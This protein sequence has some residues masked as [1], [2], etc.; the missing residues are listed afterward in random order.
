MFGLT[1]NETRILQ[2]LSTPIRIQNFL[3]TLDMNFEMQGDTCM[4]PRR[5]LATRKAQCMEGAMFAALALRMHG[6]PP[7]LVDLEATAKD[8]DHVVA[9]FKKYGRWGA[10]SK[11]NHAVLR[12][13]DP[14][15]TSIRELVM[16]YFHEYYDDN[17]KKNLRAYSQ[18]INLARFDNKGW[19]TA[20]DDIWYI[21]EYLTRTHHVP[22]LPSDK[23]IVLRRADQ[24]ELDATEHVTQK[25]PKKKSRF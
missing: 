25:P 14:A 12:Y 16:S 13:R 1:K 21:P 10:L 18:P 8:F 5:V 11:T 6:F 9:V 4:S 7:L 24:V 19:V 20:S 15:Y 3:E 2:K 23:Y 22:I 17:G